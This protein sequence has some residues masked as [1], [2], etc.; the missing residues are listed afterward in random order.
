MFE[1]FQLPYDTDGLGRVLGPVMELLPADKPRF[2]VG[3]HLPSE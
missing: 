3:L 2:I 1:G